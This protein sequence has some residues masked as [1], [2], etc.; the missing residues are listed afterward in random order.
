MT[1]PILNSNKNNTTNKLTVDDLVKQYKL[2]SDF[3]N[4]KWPLKN[5]EQK[6]FARTMKIMEELGELS[7]EILTSMNLQRN[8]KIANFSREN[9]ED[10][11]A[12]V[13][14]SLI[15]LGIELDIDVETVI[16][17]KIAFTRDRFEMDEEKAA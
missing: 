2:I 15:L 11:F 14:G 10:E 13:L 7:D 4:Q 5:Q 9:V 1:Q 16:K 3:L 12:D 17:K 6:V 8:T